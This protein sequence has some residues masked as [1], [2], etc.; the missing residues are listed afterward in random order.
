MG[1]LPVTLTT[2][3]LTS[4][5]I[6]MDSVWHIRRSTTT[7]LFQPSPIMAPFPLQIPIPDL[8][9][10]NIDLQSLQGKAEKFAAQDGMNS[11]VLD[12]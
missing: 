12:I 11:N 3:E 8:K 7:C 9:Y 5:S 10:G 6:L 4:P 2:A 1:H